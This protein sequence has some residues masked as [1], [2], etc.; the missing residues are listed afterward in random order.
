MA[1]QF[2]YHMQGLTKKFGNKTILDNVHLSFYPDAKIGLVGINGAGKSTLMKIMAGVDTEVTGEHWAAEGVKVGYLP[3]EPRLDNSKTVWENV[4]EGCEDKQIF[5][6]YN[7]VAAKMA[8]EYTDEIMEEMTALQEQV[9]ARDAWDVD[10]KIEMAMQALR[11][12]PADWPV[13][14]LSGGEARR[15]AL[16]QL[17]LSKPDLLIIARRTN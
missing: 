16:C 6:A 11:C 2:C 9:D 10:S 3:Q 17:L 15:T 1:R 5:D 4:I 13:D 8:E 12:P 14:N 7:A